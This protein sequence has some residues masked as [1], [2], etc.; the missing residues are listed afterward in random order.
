MTSKYYSQ[1]RLLLQEMGHS[2]TFLEETTEAIDTLVLNTITNYARCDGS[3]SSYA[4]ISQH[5]TSYFINEY[6]L[7]R[8]KNQRLSQDWFL[9]VAS[10]TLTCLQQLS[11]IDR[12]LD[13]L[14]NAFYTQIRSIRL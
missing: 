7:Y 3:I 1:I 4:S 10:S 8:Y 2:S 9:T 12:N 6:L 5:C 13:F 11:E 14:N